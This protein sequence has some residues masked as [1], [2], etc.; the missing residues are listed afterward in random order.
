MGIRGDM[1]GFTLGFYPLC[2]FLLAAA[3]WAGEAGKPHLVTEEALD[4]VKKGP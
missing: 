1:I 2:L 4:A 3:L